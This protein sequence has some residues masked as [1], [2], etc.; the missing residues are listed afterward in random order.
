[1]KQCPVCGTTYTDTTLRYCLAD[2]N[3]LTDAGGE[4]PTLVRQGG[5]PA[6]EETIAIGR[7]GGQMR[8]EIPLETSQLR[9]PATFQS[10]ALPPASASGGIFK[11]IMVI[12][13]L[14]IFAVIAVAAGTFIYF[15]VR[16]SANSAANTEVKA[17]ASPTPVRNERE[18]LR[19]QIANL[20]RLLNE[21][22]K[23]KQSANI[24]LKIP[25]QS[26]TRTP[27]RVDSPGD[28]FLA[29]RTLPSSSAGD[30]VLKIPH[31]GKVSV[32]ACG[33][34]IR[35]VS[36]AGRWCQAT[37]N[38]YSGWVFDAYLVY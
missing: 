27:A 8:V 23:A 36:R 17:S 28:G 2:G 10:S 15:N 24:P 34:V 32:G 7:D 16:P 5:S 30:R 26:T 21:Q 31:G 37:Y 19:D 3:M 22:K 14:G 1:M 18:E 20:E 25:D 11:I 4:Q 29:L 38:G 35:P 9:P 12:I 6:G 13:G 33:P